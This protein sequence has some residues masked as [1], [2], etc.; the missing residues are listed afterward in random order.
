MSKHLP[1]HPKASKLKQKK[2][3]SMKKN[4]PGSAREEPRKPLPTTTHEHKGHRDRMRQRFLKS[5][6]RLSS[7]APHEVLELLLFYGI[8]RVNVNPV[9]HQLLKRCGTPVLF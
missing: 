8:P 4:Q 3:I 5:D 7:F 6:D 9:A 2:G 1:P